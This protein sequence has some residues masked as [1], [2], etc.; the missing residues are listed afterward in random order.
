[1]PSLQELK[2]AI[3]SD[4][5]KMMETDPDIRD[6]ILRMTREMYAGKQ[7]TESR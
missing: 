4:L 3:L 2:K 6:F 1:M 5:P 7:E